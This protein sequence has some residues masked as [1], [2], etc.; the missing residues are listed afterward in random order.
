MKRAL[1]ALVLSSLALVSCQTRPLR[2]V[3]SVDLKRYGGLWYEVARLPNV[4]QRD[5]S[6]ATAEYTLKNT[7]TIHVV[8]TEYRPDGNRKVVAGE[9]TVVPE[10]RGSRLIVK[11]PGL[12]ALLPEKK[13]GN[14]WVIACAPDYSVALVGTS[15]RRFLWLLARQPS[16]PAGI[17]DQYLAIARQQGFLTGKMI[18]ADWSQVP[19][20]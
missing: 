9:G 3:E 13:E 16:L 4:F 11:F 10:S 2:T 17:R 1:I 12:A 8:N 20:S 7:G 19:R 18:M 5:D 6:R 15:D 14:Y